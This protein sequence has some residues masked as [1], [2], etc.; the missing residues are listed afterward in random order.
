ME[1]MKQRDDMSDNEILAEKAIVSGAGQIFLWTIAGISLFATPISSFEIACMAVI[2]LANVGR[3][4]CGHF[5]SDFRSPSVWY[6]SYAS[7]TLITPIAW[8]T[9]GTRFIFE[10]GFTTEF[11]VVVFIINAGI[12]A[13]ATSALSPDRFLAR[14]FIVLSL[15]P[16]LASLLF[17]STPHF[18]IAGVITIYAVFL[19]FQIKL[20]TSNVEKLRDREALVRALVNASIE[21]IAIHRDNII[22]ECNR[23]FEVMLGLAPGEAIGRDILTF[24]LPED[25][26]EH[27][28][29]LG[30]ESMKRQARGLRRD[31]SEFPI[32]IYGHWFQFKGEKTRV[33][34]VMDIHKS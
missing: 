14:V 8:S 31:G 21:G 30:Q 33:T 15:V 18:Y 20:Q 7:A 3:M 2:F 25:R 1:F 9:L 13:A 22:I 6:K 23:A 10:H 4:A 17:S 28:R 27:M 11:S 29:R 16:L 32:E 19:F 12:V 26:P 5:Y 34:C 24:T